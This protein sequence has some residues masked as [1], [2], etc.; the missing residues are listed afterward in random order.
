[1]QITFRFWIL[2]SEVLWYVLFLCSLW[3]CE[4]CE[5]WSCEFCDFFTYCYVIVIVLLVPLDLCDTTTFVIISVHSTMTG[6]N[7]VKPDIPM[8]TFNNRQ[9][10]GRQNTARAVTNQRMTNYSYDRLVAGHAVVL[11]ASCII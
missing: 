6:T 8:Q 7:H 5:F 10:Y 9:R 4:F 1:M 3:S 2:C 11:M